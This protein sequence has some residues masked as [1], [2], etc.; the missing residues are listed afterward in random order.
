M[1]YLLGVDV[2]TTTTKAV[3]YDENATIIGHFSKGYPL[4]RDPQGMAEQD[5]EEIL[6]AVETVIRVSVSQEDL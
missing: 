6:A 5:P 3:L 1:K 2:G 4:Y